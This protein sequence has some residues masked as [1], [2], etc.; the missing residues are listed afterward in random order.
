MQQQKDIKYNLIE[1]IFRKKMSDEFG[2][3]A[4]EKQKDYYRNKKPN[5]IKWKL[6]KQSKIT[7]KRMMN[8]VQND[9]TYA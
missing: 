2:E 7:R 9:P 4:R 3:N 5:I 1:L 8:Q 6:E